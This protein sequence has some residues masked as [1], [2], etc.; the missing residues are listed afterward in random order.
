MQA[1]RKQARGRQKLLHAIWG[2]SGFNVGQEGMQRS[3][4]SSNPEYRGQYI[5]PKCQSIHVELC[6]IISLK[7]VLTVSAVGISNPAFKKCK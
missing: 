3:N 5:D 7:T 1:S 4:L 2:K 6:G